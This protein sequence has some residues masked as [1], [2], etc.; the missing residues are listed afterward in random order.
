MEIWRKQVGKCH[1]GGLNASLFFKK[2]GIETEFKDRE[3]GNK[4]ERKDKFAFRKTS[5]IFRQKS[6]WRMQLISIE[7]VLIE[8]FFIHGLE[9]I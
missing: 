1:Q 5:R 3:K 2:Q 8:S 7:N 6:T 9:N 4:K